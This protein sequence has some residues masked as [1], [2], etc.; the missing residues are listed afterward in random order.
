MKVR[1]TVCAPLVIFKFQMT[2]TVQKTENKVGYKNW[3]NHCLKLLIV[4]QKSIT[5]CAKATSYVF[6]VILCHYNYETQGVLNSGSR[7]TYLKLIDLSTAL[8]LILSHK[9]LGLLQ[10]QILKCLPLYMHTLMS[11][12]C[13]VEAC[14]VAIS[15][16]GHQCWNDFDAACFHRVCYPWTQTRL[17]I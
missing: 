5:S 12:C 8:V 11:S 10:Q 17:D 4:F 16:S 7:C 13:L 2:K 15:S 1:D 14:G 6:C 3:I 9:F